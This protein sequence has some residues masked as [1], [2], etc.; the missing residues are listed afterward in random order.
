[1]VST[2]FYGQ[3]QSI[4]NAA[5]KKCVGGYFIKAVNLPRFWYFWAHFIDYQVR[6]LLRDRGGSYRR[7][8]PRPPYRFDHLACSPLPYL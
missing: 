5:Y 4:A 8:N 2:S 1:M 7:L 6:F 3:P